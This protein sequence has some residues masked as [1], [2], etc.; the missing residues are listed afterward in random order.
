[1]QTYLVAGDK[2]L[3]SYWTLHPKRFSGFVLGQKHYCPSQNNGFHMG[4]NAKL[5]CCGGTALDGIT[6]N[7]QA[8]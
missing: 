8:L 5:S 6:R 1:M 7:E 4:L 3:S 2:S